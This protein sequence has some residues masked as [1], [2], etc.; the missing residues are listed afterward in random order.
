MLTIDQFLARATTF[1]DEGE[2]VAFLMLL[3]DDCSYLTSTTVLSDKHF[4]LLI[5]YE[6]LLKCGLPS[7]PVLNFIK[8]NIYLFDQKSDVICDAIAR[9]EKERP[10]LLLIAVSD[11][12]FIQIPTQDVYDIK[13]GQL[14][15][16]A[17]SG[18]TGLTISVSGAIRKFMFNSRKHTCCC[19]KEREVA[20]L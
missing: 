2:V 9:D 8:Q 14:C 11:M 15:D 5:V 16:N 19:N 4:V 10:S 3:D 1:S 17:T 13:T 12:R 20:I 7:L 18:V 6:E